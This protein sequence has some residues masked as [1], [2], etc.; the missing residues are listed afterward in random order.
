MNEP[1]II[2]AELTWTGERFERGI[3]ITVNGGRIDSLGRASQS[4]TERLSRI[5]LLPGFVNAHSHAFQR[6]L[7]GRGELFPRGAGTFWSWREAMYSLAAGLDEKRFFDLTSQAFREMLRAGIT[8]V[9]EFHYL[10]HTGDR[11]EFDL[12]EV[13]LRAAEQTGIRIALLTAFYRTGGIGRPLEGAQQ[14][15]ATPSLDDFWLQF[16]RLEAR[17]APQQ[18]LG[19]VAHSIRA[20]PLRDLVALHREAVRRGVVFH[21][22]VEEQRQEMDQCVEAH[23]RRP[24]QILLD[25]LELSPSFTAIHC[26]HTDR[27]DLDRFLATGA[28]VCITPLTEANLGDGVIDVQP[29]RRTPSAI[30]LGTDSSSRISMLEEMR[31]LEY[32]Q[33]LRGETRGVFTTPDGQLGPAL[34][35]AATSGGAAALGIDAGALAPG[36]WADLVAIDLDHESLAGADDESLL[37]ALILGSGNEAVA[38]AAVAGQWKFRRW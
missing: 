17:L 35:R 4:A 24:M 30:C 38:G 32:A 25:D 2:E 23:G 7:R 34:L 31:W 28:H 15:F 36:L 16:E 29:I 3:A 33:R 19:V 1:T 21:M 37:D 13:V 8:S 26:T 27:D 9:G 20:V 12:D 18:T 22:H 11:C 6:G 14:R 5:A 10:H